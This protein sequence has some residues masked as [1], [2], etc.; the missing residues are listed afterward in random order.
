MKG[1][2]WAARV[3]YRVLFLCGD[4]R[5]VQAARA[6]GAR[7]EKHSLFQPTRPLSHDFSFFSPPFISGIGRP[8]EHMPVAS[9]VLQDFAV[10]EREDVDR[11]VEEAADAV[12]AVLGLGLEKALSGVRLVKK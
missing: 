8:P 7:A 3:F 9:Y 5:A 6:R 4:T 1:R 10:S 12:C 2:Q 11:A